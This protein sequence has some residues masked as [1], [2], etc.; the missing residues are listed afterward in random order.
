M[1]YVTYK[2]GYTIAQY[3]AS[4]DFSTKGGF[5]LPLNLGFIFSDASQ[6][7]GI[8]LGAKIPLLGYE[9]DINAMGGTVELR[10]YIVHVGYNYTF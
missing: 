9:Y 5:A 3:P 7:H 6:R 2:P 8:I 10:D 4:L 1:G